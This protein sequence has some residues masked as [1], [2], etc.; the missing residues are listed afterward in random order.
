MKAFDYLI[1]NK[2]ITIDSINYAYIGN[3][4]YFVVF[5]EDFS[6]IVKRECDI[7]VNELLMRLEVFKPTKKE[8][9]LNV[10]EIPE[11][12]W[13][14]DSITSEYDFSSF[15]H[16]ICPKCFEKI[17]GDTC[18][19]IGKYGYCHHCNAR[20]F[21]AVRFDGVR[22]DGY[23]LERMPREKKEKQV[24]EE[25]DPDELYASGKLKTLKIK[26]KVSA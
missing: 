20:I 14:H 23:P 4:V 16:T 21:K 9:E 26:L 1:N 13:N 5:N 6:S 22:E 24:I 2:I 15:P 12:Y 8:G 10:R 19:K 7:P 3:R 17:D 18:I 25:V 11:S